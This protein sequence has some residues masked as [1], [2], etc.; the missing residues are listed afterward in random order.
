M[1]CVAKDCFNKID[2]SCFVHAD[3]WRFK[4]RTA[5]LMFQCMMHHLCAWWR[6]VGFLRRFHVLFQHPEQKENISII[7]YYRNYHLSY[8]CTAGW[9]SYCATHGVWCVHVLKHEHAGASDDIFLAAIWIA[10]RYQA[11]NLSQ[12]ATLPRYSAKLSFSGL[13][14]ACFARNQ[15]VGHGPHPRTY[16]TIMD[17]HT[18]QENWVLTT[19]TTD[20]CICTSNVQSAYFLCTHTLIW[21]D[22]HFRYWHG[23]WILV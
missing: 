19:T 10:Q 18:D 13:D 9:Y 4:G 23:M 3:C 5:S 12:V 14:G 20:N 21:A 17:K 7:M 22:L 11:L 16:V 15:A 1:G 6:C 8:L 2:R